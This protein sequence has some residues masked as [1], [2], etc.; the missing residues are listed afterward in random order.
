PPWTGVGPG[1]I[2]SRSATGKL[3]GCRPSA[4]QSEKPKTTNRIQETTNRIKDIT[5]RTPATSNPVLLIRKG[6]P[7]TGR[8]RRTLTNEST[9][10]TKAT[11]ARI[12]PDTGTLIHQPE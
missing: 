10:R 6:D 12:T 11:R 4:G 3:L 9:P 5:K 1:G 8:V 2:V 7:G